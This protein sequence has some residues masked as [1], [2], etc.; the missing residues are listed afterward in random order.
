MKRGQNH[1]AA[2]ESGT[3]EMSVRDQ[4][5]ILNQNCVHEEIKSRLNSG[6]ACYHSV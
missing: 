6:S 3:K 5:A 2:H 1:R 4:A